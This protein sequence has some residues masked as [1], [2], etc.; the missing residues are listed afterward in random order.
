[1]E[2]LLNE[3]VPQADLEVNQQY[4]RSIRRPAGP[5]SI[6]YES[7]INIKSICWWIVVQYFQYAFREI[8]LAIVVPNKI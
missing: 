5:H 1:M 3:I 6:F 4:L 8:I 7:I 2:E